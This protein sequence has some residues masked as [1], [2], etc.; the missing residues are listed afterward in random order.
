MKNYFG[1]LLILCL[2]S[3]CATQQKLSVKNGEL[4]E[5]L[6]V[7]LV[8]SA[9]I[10]TEDWQNFSLETDKF[11]NDYNLTDRK[12]KLYPALTDS[13]SVKININENNYVTKGQ[14]MTGVFVTAAGI[15]TPIL[16]IAKR[17][18]IYVSFSYNPKNKIG[19]SKSLS[20]DLDPSNKQIPVAINTRHQFQSLDRQK[21]KQKIAYLAFLYNLMNEISIE[22]SSTP[23]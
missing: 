5:R 13:N 22:K 10:S 19:I 14:Q 8:K 20:K 6:G 7:H 21:E 12:F 11:I 9:N 16:M 18:P 3:S 1:I 2:L 23:N 15:I 4:P 17:A